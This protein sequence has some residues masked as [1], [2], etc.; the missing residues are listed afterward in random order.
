M[1]IDGTLSAT[2]LN[3]RDTGTVLEPF[4]KMWRE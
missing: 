4:R 1:E 2:T 3:V